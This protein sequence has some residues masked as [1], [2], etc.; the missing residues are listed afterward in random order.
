ML[1]QALLMM[2]GAVYEGKNSLKFI[3]TIVSDRYKKVAVFTD[4]GI[5]SSGIVDYP[6][7]L[8]RKCNAKVVVFDELPAEPTCDEA[9]K[10]VD[11]FRD[12]G[13][14]FIIA[15]GG[16]SVMDV[17]KLASIACTGEYTIRELLQT[18]LMGRKQVKTL[19]IPTTAGTG[20]EAT[21]NSIVSVPEQKLKVG[22]VNPQMLA[23][24][25][26]LDGSMLHGLPKN[27]AA[28]T[29]LDALAHAVECFTSNKANAFSNM[30]AAEA[31]RLIFCNIVP[32]CEEEAAEEARCNMLRAA[33][34]A[35]IAITSSG[36]TAV[37][38]LSYPL[39]GRYHIPHGV[40]NAIL[41]LPVLKFN[42]E[43]CLSEYAELYDIAA[44][45]KEADIT[46]E[47]KAD[48][49]LEQLEGIIRRLEIP[50]SLKAFGIDASDLESL[51]QDGMEVKRLLNNNK[52]PVTAENA[53][54][55]YSQIL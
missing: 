53:R 14:D 15:I 43:A 2:P 55:I 8:L 7:E 47:E 29:G 3:E 36:T 17:A 45:K 49:L 42:K 27:I 50:L 19:M 16:G 12:S 11:A 34:Y 25:V 9:Q 32:A 20:S 6:L 10:A 35:G 30:F 1:E 38:A 52:R 24:T 37:H 54:N 46:Q 51:V 31:F 26:I 48:W 4:K 28:S 39:G 44:D 5:R 18:P 21:P 40:S 41:L 13:C 22:I 33:F 23:D